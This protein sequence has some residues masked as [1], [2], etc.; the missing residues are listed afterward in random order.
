MNRR[1]SRIDEPRSDGERE[2]EVFLRESASE[3]LRHAGSVTAP[4]EET[5]REVAEPLFGHAVE[6]LWLC[7]ADEIGRYAERTLGER[8]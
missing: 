2:W 5:A 6:A 3:P 8:A 7:P 4:T 1:L